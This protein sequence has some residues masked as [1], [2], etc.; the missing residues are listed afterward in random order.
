VIPLRV[1]R[2]HGSTLGAKRVRRLIRERQNDT[3]Q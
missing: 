2:E 1:G 3:E